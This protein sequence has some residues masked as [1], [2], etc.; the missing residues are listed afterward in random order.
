MEY[1]TQAYLGSDLDLFFQNFSTS[2]IGQRP[3]LVSID[4]GTV[5]YHAVLMQLAEHALPLQV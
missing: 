1:A 3:K 2:Q 5:C 4:G